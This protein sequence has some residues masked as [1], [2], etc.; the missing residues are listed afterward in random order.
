[1]RKQFLMVLVGL[2][3]LSWPA[4]A[5]FAM[6]KM[7]LEFTPGSP[8]QDDIQIISQGDDT[9]YIA[10]EVYTVENPGETNEKRTLVK[11]P[12]ISGLMVTPNKIVLPPRARK[13]MRFLLL[14]EQ[15]AEE[16]IYR[17]VVKPV[18]QGVESQKQRMALKL[19]VGYEALVIVRPA[20]A[21]IDLSAERQGN[22]LVLTNKGNTNANL[23]TGEQ[24]DAMGANCKEINV[25][26]IYAGQS[27]KTSLPYIDGKV[28]FQVWDGVEMRD[29]FF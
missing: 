10:T 22:S 7:I 5:E 6:S 29:M 9:Q 21:Q 24:C 27:W 15:P 4:R 3:L 17:V 25:S 28:K 2:S 14:K 18:I 8:R 20:N 16:L 11:D 23:Q 12:K 1:M 13:L 19:L 26:R